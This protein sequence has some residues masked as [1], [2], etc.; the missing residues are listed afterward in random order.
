MQRTLKRELKVPEIA[1]GEGLKRAAAS[2]SSAVGCVAKSWDLWSLI[3]P[4]FWSNVFDG[5][6]GH[7]V[8]R[9]CRG[10]KNNFSLVTS[11][12]AVGQ[13]LG[14]IYSPTTTIKGYRPAPFWRQL[15]LLGL[16]K[17]WHKQLYWIEG[18]FTRAH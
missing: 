12:S 6:L 17:V 10:V 3:G 18:G 8:Q 7:T 1:N 9:D 13:R 16:L 15:G 5:V 11:A 2:V 14:W 4:A